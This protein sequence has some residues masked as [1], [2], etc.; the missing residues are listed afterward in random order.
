MIYSTSP[1]ALLH[2]QSREVVQGLH[3]TDADPTPEKHVLDH[4]EHHGSP[5]R[6]HELDHTTS[7]I[8]LSALKFLDYQA[9]MICR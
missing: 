9:G 4:A 2:L 5:T 3:S 1:T 7:G 8:D 6:Q